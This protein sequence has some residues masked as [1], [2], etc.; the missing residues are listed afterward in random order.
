MQTPAVFNAA[1]EVAVQLFLEGRIRFGG[2]A[3]IIERVLARH[4]GGD[5]G[6]LEAVLAADADARRQ[7]R[8]VVCP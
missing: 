2:I 3:E 7:A 4:D 6:S 1:N 5:A 8:E